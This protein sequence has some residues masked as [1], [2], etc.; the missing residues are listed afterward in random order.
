MRPHH[1]PQPHSTACRLVRSRGWP[2][3]LPAHL[4]SLVP[5]RHWRVSLIHRRDGGEQESAGG[6]SDDHESRLFV[7]MGDFH[8]PAGSAEGL[9]SCG[10]EPNNGGGYYGVIHRSLL[11]CEPGASVRSGQEQT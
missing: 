4:S 2:A 10:V 7:T 9:K 6:I 1:G 5:S 8:G 3:V 11:F